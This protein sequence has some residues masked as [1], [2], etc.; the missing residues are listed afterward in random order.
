MKVIL[1]GALAE[2]AA[3]Q[4]FE[5]PVEGSTTREDLLA[6][7]SGQVPTIARYLRVDAESQKPVA[8]MVVADGDWVHPGDSVGAGAVVEICPPITGG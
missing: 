8:I 3:Q 6:T 5:L 7:L 4:E 1:R 2:G